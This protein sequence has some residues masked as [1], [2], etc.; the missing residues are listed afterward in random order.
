MARRQ[1]TDSQVVSGG[2]MLVGPLNPLVRPLFLLA[3]SQSVN[4][5]PDWLGSLVNLRSEH[6]KFGKMFYRIMTPGA[7]LAKFV[8]GLQNVLVPSHVKHG[9][10]ATGDRQR[11]GTTYLWSRCMTYIHVATGSDSRPEC[12][13]LDQDSN[14]VSSAGQVLQFL[15]HNVVQ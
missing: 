4:S 6:F 8:L 7:G 12:M 9:R 11:T 15:S 5:G 13:S 10:L 1:T 14:S 3:F 2:M